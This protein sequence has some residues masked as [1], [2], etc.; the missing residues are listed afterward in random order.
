MIERVLED[1]DYLR[2]SMEADEWIGFLVE[3]RKAIE[4]RIDAAITG[5]TGANRE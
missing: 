1:I 2:G 3:L 5:P 4:T